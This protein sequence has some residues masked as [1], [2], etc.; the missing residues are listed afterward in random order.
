MHYLLEKIASWQAP[1]DDA[2]TRAW[3]QQVEH[4]LSGTADMALGEF[5]PAHLIDFLAGAMERVAKVHQR[6]IELSGQMGALRET[7]AAMDA[8]EAREAAGWRE[9]GMG[10]Q[11]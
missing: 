9:G 10:S 5:I 3:A 4:T 6:L 2:D 8:Q 7:A 11:D 1:A